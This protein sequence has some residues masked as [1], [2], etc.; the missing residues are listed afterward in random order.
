MV[1][2]LAVDSFQRRR[3]V[4]GEEAGMTANTSAL[5]D[6]VRAMIGVTGEKVEASLL[7]IEREG[8]R[9]FT[10]AIMDPDPRYWDDAFA[11]S[12]RYGGIVTP[13][14]YCT[15]LGRKTPAGADDPVSRAFRENPNCDG[16]AGIEDSG[17]GALPPVPTNLR[18]SL[19][20]GNEIEV[21][22]YP[23]LGDQ[24]FSQAKYADIAEKIG[25]DGKPFLI[26][27]TEVIYTDQDGAELCILRQVRLRR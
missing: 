25:K 14:I 7:G 18:R 22:K 21:Y 5:T 15:Y 19:N 4:S 9:R 6:E 1:R 13:P 8:L 26:I 2:W 16:V 10:Q 3:A 12:T 23:M 20:G 27:T 17:V 11:K 24:I